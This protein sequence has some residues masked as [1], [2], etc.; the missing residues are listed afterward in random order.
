MLNREQ[1]HYL[2]EKALH[3]GF[4]VEGPI[5]ENGIIISDFDDDSIK[6]EL[7]IIDDKNNTRI[8]EWNEVTDNMQ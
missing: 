2:K 4:F 3:L 1:I 7:Y 6:Y 5:T 8:R